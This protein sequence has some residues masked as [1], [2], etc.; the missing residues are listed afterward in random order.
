MSNINVN[1]LNFGELKLKKETKL[2]DIANK[3]QEEFKYPIVLANVN[4][5]LFDLNKRLFYDSNIEFLDIKSKYGY[6]TYQNSIVFLLVYVVK[7]ILGKDA[8]VVI[9]NSINKNYYCEIIDKNLK[10]SKELLDEISLEM[11][12][13]VDQDLKIEKVTL[14]L[15]EAIEYLKEF[16]LYDKIKLLNYS[17]LDSID[18]YKIN[19]FYNYFIDYIV[20]STG[21]LKIF[22]L[23]KVSEGFLLI[24]PDPYNPNILNEIKPLKK[25]G[26]VFKES[27]NWTKILKIET[28]GDLNNQISSGYSKDIIRVSEAL[29]EKKIA[30]IA[31]SIHNHN[32]KIILIAGPSSSGKTTFAK[33]LEVQLR[34]NGLLAHIISLDDYYLDREHIPKD[35]F[36]ELDFECLEA[37]DVKKVNEDLE[38]LLKGKEIDLPKFNFKLGKKE[39]KGNY[40]K[41]GKDDVLIIEGI[42]G[43]NYQIAS[44]ISNSKKFKIFISALTQINLDDHNK[45]STTDARLIRRIVRDNKFRQTDAATNISMWNS[46]IRGEITNI[47]PY[48]EDADVIFNS[49]LIY[50][51]SVLKQYAEPLLFCIDRDMSQYNEAKRLIKLLDKFLSIECSKVPDNSILRE[52]IG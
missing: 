20:P 44:N 37:I 43:L 41:M 46:V 39:Y 13:L 10:L 49:S 12:R 19:N 47:F 50:E 38:M 21:Y 24:M 17:C 35:K 15:E 11:H 3:Y 18:L 23:V 52:F 4:N 28:A 6:R 22:D 25:L 33:R 9:K 51:I 27:Y 34:V 31:D 5:E 42:H 8:R 48:Q 40:L 32:K 7:Q 26:K 45:I 16:Q 29:Q 14:E 2:L 1:I 30:N 36:G